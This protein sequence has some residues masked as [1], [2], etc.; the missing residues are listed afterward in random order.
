MQLHNLLD[1]AR[2]QIPEPTR[3]IT[4]R[5][6]VR[7]G[8]GDTFMVDAPALLAFVDDRAAAAARRE[9]DEILGREAA[10]AREAYFRKHQEL[11]APQPPQAL[12]VERR[13]LCEITMLHRALRDPDD[14]DK[15]LAR[16]AEEL[17]GALVDSERRRLWSAYEMLVAEEFPPD[18]TDAEFAALVEDAKKKSLADLVSSTGSAPILRALPYLVGLFGQS[19]TRT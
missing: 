14:R 6:R 16:S 17:R 10:E 9:A 18:I 13:I 1:T 19:P 8:K 4:A 12:D 3:A 11:P 5:V 15:P 7:D 2:L